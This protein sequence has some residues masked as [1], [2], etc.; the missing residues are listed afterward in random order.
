MEF[1]L[2]HFPRLNDSHFI[3]EN[4][5]QSCETKIYIPCIVF[6]KNV[7]PTQTKTVFDVDKALI[8]AKS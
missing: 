1:I 5:I 7:A 3:V 4:S 6:S 8:T 2:T